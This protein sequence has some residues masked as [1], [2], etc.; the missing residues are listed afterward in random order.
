MRLSTEYAK[1]VMAF[2]IL[3]KNEY[4]FYLRNFPLESLRIR[5]KRRL[6]SKSYRA[7]A[8]YSI[9]KLDETKFKV[10]QVNSED[11]QE[12]VLKVLTQFIEKGQDADLKLNNRFKRN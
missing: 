11:P 12:A 5:L 8:S 3:K 9:R 4:E 10:V 1:W 2:K 6:F 7:K